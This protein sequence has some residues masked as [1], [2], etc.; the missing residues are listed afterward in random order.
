ML[1]GPDEED[2][3]QRHDADGEDGERQFLAF[4]HTLPHTRLGLHGLS[5]L[6]HEATSHNGSTVLG[7]WV[8]CL[9]VSIYA[10]AKGRISVTRMRQAAPSLRLSF[11]YWSSV[12]TARKA[13]GRSRQS[14]ARRGLRRQ[15]KRCEP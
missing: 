9:K 6:L 10:D 15:T 4:L 2:R 3:H 7:T 13:P 5:S 8:T 1:E 14:A 12:A 11:S